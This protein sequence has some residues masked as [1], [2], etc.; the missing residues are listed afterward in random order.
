MVSSTDFEQCAPLWLSVDSTIHIAISTSH[1]GRTESEVAGII[2]SIGFK[3][4]SGFRQGFPRL[5]PARG[6]TKNTPAHLATGDEFR[7]HDAAVL[8]ARTARAT[9][10]LLTRTR[11]LPASG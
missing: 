9:A 11:P 5:P 1:Y 8:T 7:R 3:V 2:H 4:Y 6:G 10:D